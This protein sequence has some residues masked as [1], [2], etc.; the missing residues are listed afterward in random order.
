MRVV[1]GVCQSVTR[2]AA[3]TPWRQIFYALLDLQDSTEPDAIDELT[4]TVQAE[5][6]GWT[7]RLSVICWVCQF[8][9]TRRQPRS[10]AR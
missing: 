6:P 7:L 5:H 10:T 8:L 1:M 4:S 9:I 3:Y 2:S